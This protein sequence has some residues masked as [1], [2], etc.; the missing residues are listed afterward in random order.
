M[1]KLSGQFRNTAWDPILI[2]SQIVAVQSV[3]YLTLGVW[4]LALDFV[5]GTSRSL[6]HVF[7]YQEIHSRDSIG[8]LVIVAFLLNALT[9]AVSLWCLVQ[10]TKLCLD[11][12]CTVHFLHLILCWIY[13]GYF[14]VS[15]FWWVLNIVSAGIMCIC[16]ELLCMR[17]ELKAIPLSSP[18]KVVGL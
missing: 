4:L 9:G 3:F 15:L 13:N 2:V 8:K 18:P 17:T 12:A 6:D 16:G 7:K 1:S 5:V 11:F 10:R 14:P